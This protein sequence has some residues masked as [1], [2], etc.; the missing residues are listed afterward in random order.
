[1]SLELGIHVREVR[2]K[3]D[4]KAFAKQ[5]PKDKNPERKRE[6]KERTMAF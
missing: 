1:M 3:M 5:D 2:F 6:P 4:Y